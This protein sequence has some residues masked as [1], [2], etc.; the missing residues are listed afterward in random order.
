MPEPVR[1]L[2]LN[3]PN[4]NLIGLR[5]PEVYGHGTL[6]ELEDGLRAAFP[7]VAFTF[8]QH[9]H[10]G[11]LID[12]LHATRADGTAGVVMNAG[13]FSHTS[14]ALRDAVA[15]IAPVPVVE[16]HIT[17]VHARETFRHTLLTAGACVG[18][19]AGLGRLGYHLAVRFLLDRAAP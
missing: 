14:I 1:L 8:A 10:E 18:S 4:L 16:V 5:E 12:A 9:N 3:G 15:A 19:I 6:A 13:A 7:E 2:V 17:N 11:A